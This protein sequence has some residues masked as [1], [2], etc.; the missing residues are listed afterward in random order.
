VTGA[1]RETL[2]E[3]LASPYAD[4]ELLTTWAGATLRG[5]VISR[6]HQSIPIGMIELDEDG[7]AVFHLYAEPEPVVP[8]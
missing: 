4:V 1:G 3:L 2:G 6:V 5:W 7:D 8:F